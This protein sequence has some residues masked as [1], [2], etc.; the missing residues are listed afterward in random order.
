MTLAHHQNSETDQIP[1][2]LL[3]PATN[4]NEEQHNTSMDKPKPL[5]IDSPLLQSTSN[6]GA[7]PMKKRP[8]AYLKMASPW[9]HRCRVRGE[10]A[11]KEFAKLPP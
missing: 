11:T 1:S 4:E 5:Q 3:I 6:N 8:S 2:V 7:A 9:R 10:P